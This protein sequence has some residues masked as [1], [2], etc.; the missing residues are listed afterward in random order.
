MGIFYDKQG[1]NQK[2]KLYYNKSI[3]SVS[4]DSYLVSSN[5]RNIG[6]I[7]FKEAIIIRDAHPLGLGTASKYRNNLGYLYV[8][9]GMIPEANIILNEALNRYVEFYN[10]DTSK[11]IST[12]QIKG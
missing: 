3:K 11:Y 7:Y 5:Y 6:E 1:L 4:Q 10:S 9:M 8:S 12:I 2:A